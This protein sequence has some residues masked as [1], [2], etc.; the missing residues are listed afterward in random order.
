LPHDRF[1]N[2]ELSRLDFDGRVLS[3]AEDV[4]RPLA[5][6]IRFLAIVSDSL[7]D[8]FQVRVAGLREQVM[9]PLALTSP[10]GMTPEEQLHGIGERVRALVQRQSTMFT[11]DIEPALARPASGSPQR[12]TSQ[13]PTALCSRI[14]FGSASFRC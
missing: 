4:A 14:F 1:F 2:R 5:E 8:F 10:D 6:R 13:S 12:P 9:A 3:M 11:A 7:D